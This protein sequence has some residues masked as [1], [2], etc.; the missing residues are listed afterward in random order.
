MPPAF[1]QW[2]SR[3]PASEV[4]AGT[5]SAGTCYPRVHHPNLPPTQRACRF[6]RSHRLLQFGTG[7]LRHSV[8]PVPAAS[9]TRLR[10][11]NQYRAGRNSHNRFVKNATAIVPVLS[12][13]RAADCQ[14][15][16]ISSARAQ[17]RYEKLHH[18]LHIVLRLVAGCADGHAF[19]EKPARYRLA[20]EIRC[21][22]RGIHLA[23][24]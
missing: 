16:D 5:R 9:A 20:D 14:R 12:N 7:K 2:D 17:F 4:D 13:E 3:A 15:C 21:S 8:G 10:W 22:E 19:S 24:A 1:V 23:G 6:S 11:R 18:F